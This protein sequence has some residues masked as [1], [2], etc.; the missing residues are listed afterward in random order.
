MSQLHTEEEILRKI[1]LLPRELAPENDPWPQISSRIGSTTRHSVTTAGR[2]RWWPYAVAA[3]VVLTVAS[4]LIPGK[5]WNSSSPF[6]AAPELARQYPGAGISPTSEAAYQAAF[7]EFMT[8]GV[9]HTA[10]LQHS[11]Q[12]FDT[13]WSAMRQ[14]EVQLQG[15]LNREPDSVLLNSHL[16]ALRARQLK[17]LQQIQAVDMAAW[18]NTI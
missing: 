8:S 13:G 14:A 3:A 11:M 1:S 7:R 2:A 5:L 18:R 17:L 6:P 15:A 4:L 16:Q 9:A 12:G 10:S